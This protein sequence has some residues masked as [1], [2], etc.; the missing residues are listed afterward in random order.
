MVDLQPLLNK[1]YERSGYDL[2]LDY[3][4]EPVPSFNHED[5]HWIHNLLTDKGLR[6]TA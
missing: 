3:Q 1:L 5:T 4:K 6:P 2:K